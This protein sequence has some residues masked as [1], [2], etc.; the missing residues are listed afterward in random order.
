M[1]LG[2][3]KE[4]H[5]FSRQFLERRSKWRSLNRSAPAEDDMCTP[6]PAVNPLTTDFTE[7]KGKGKKPKKNKMFR[8]DNRILGFNVT[9]AEDRINVGD[10][11]FVE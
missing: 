11:D 4:T 2:D 8:V 9:A 10:R 3:G 5:E 1:Y 6:A 7:V